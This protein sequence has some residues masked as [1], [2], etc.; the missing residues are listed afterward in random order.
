MADCNVTEGNAFDSYDAEVPISSI[1][2]GFEANHAFVINEEDDVVIHK[3]D[4]VSESDEDSM[5]HFCQPCA[6]RTHVPDNQSPNI[7][8]KPPNVPNKVPKVPYESLYTVVRQA[9]HNFPKN[10][11]R[12][13]KDFSTRIQVKDHCRHY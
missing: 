9:G 2:F 6:T 8:V 12:A 11:A 3:E 13:K 5:D 7:P 4:E 10:K 1:D